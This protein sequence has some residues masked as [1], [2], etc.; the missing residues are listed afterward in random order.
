MSQACYVINQLVIVILNWWCFKQDCFALK[1]G[2]AINM[3]VRDFPRI[4]VDIDLAYLPLQPRDESMQGISD[5][6]KAM[7]ADM[8]V[9][10]GGACTITPHRTQGYNIKLT[11][12]TDQAVVKIEPNT[13]LRGS[14]HPPESRDL[15][16]TAQQELLAFVSVPVLSEADLYGG[17]LCAALD[18][19]HPR[20]LFDVQLLLEDQGIT[21][22]I[23][24]GFVIYLAS[25]NRPMNELL[26]PNVLDI[27]D[28][29]QKEFEGMTREPTRLPDLLN[30][31][32]QLPTLLRDDLTETERSFLLSMKQGEP[33]WELLDIAHLAEM[34]ALQWK[35][36][37]IRKMTPE[38]RAVEMERL[39]RVLAM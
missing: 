23:R 34:P 1:G 22:E 31:Q 4:S 36:Q 21:E 8:Q 7:Q 20:D 27:Q 39:Q 30:V 14:V 5:A 15:V 28:L 24:R 26:N 11:V 37:N 2:T 17:K 9:A 38:K 33:D 35:L 13:I 19:Q 12:R 25:H 18:R 3:F 10:L 6:L 16:E 29:Y 32:A